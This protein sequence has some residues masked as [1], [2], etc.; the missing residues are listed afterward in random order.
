MKKPAIEWKEI[1]REGMF[2]SPQLVQKKIHRDLLGYLVHRAN[3]KNR[4]CWSSQHE[5]ARVQDCSVR[6]T[7]DLLDY[8]EEIGA[9]FRVKIVDLPK[10]E[11]VMIKVL[12]PEKV[13]RNA[14]AYY[15]CEEWAKDQIEAAAQLSD[16]DALPIG[17]AVADQK[18]G[19]DKANERRR[20]YIPDYL[21]DAD[22]PSHP[23]HDE[24]LFINAVPAE[25]GSPTSPLNVGETGSP[26]TDMTN[27]YNPDENSAPMMGLDGSA[28]APSSQ[29]NLHT[30][31]RTSPTSQ[32]AESILHGYGGGE[33]GAPVPRTKS[34]ARPEGTEQDAARACATDRR[35]S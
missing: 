18:R 31:Y 26:T 28:I 10:R 7:K 19:R 12:T 17:I 29:A 11:Q 3:R 14:N 23:T 27:E 13:T 24:W 35:A 33:A 2:A 15:L 21:A 6:N 32:H 4:L 25:T 34:L 20:R 1:F 9:I 16:Q 8:L 30:T 5:L 22:I